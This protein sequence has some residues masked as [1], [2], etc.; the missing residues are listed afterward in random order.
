MMYM[1][2]E[3]AEKDFAKAAEW[4]H[5]RGGARRVKAQTF[6]G[7]MLVDGDGVSKDAS[8]AAYFL[9]L[10]AEQGVSAR[11]NYDREYVC[12]WD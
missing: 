6:L 5:A 11:S 2:G 4:L 12:R 1:K 10:A 9:E 3:G 7:T 8:K